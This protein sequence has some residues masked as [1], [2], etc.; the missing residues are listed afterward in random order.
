MPIYCYKC[1]AC[2]NKVE[3]FQ[4]TAEE[5]IKECPQCNEKMERIISPVGVIFKGSGFH[6]TDYKKE[7]IT[8]DNKSETKEEKTETKT[9]EKADSKTETKAE[10]PKSESKPEK[11]AKSESKSKESKK[12]KEVA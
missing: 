10:P 6:I 2:G 12:K 1:Y 7:H 5:A 3:E 9:E 11:A 4:K 8:R